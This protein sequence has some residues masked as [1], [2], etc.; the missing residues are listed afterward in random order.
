MRKAILIIGILIILLELF[1]F[2]NYSVIQKEMAEQMNAIIAEKTGHYDTYY[3][4]GGF[5]WIS[6]ISIILG[7]ALII[8]SRK[9][10]NTQFKKIP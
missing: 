7:I 9:I 2:Y 5:D 1:S 6:I 8:I 10:K 4:I 3:L